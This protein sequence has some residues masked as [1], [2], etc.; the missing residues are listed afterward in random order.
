MN[1]TRQ[2]ISPFGPV[3]K[4]GINDDV[5]RAPY[6]IPVEGGN[7]FDESRARFDVR[8][9]RRGCL[10]LWWWRR[11]YYRLTPWWTS[12]L[13]LAVVPSAVAMILPSRAAADRASDYAY[14]STLDEFG[15]HYGSEPGIIELG[16]TVCAALD[17]GIET[18][19][20]ASVI[21]QAAHYSPGDANT[22]VGASIGSY[23]D[24]HIPA[25]A[26]KPASSGIG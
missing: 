2:G 13:L 10:H 22:I 9:P 3:R 21:A 14:L 23:C 26:T 11:L 25:A 8:Y 5:V 4:F 24:Q 20:I 15:V 16:H 18:G 19:R 7:S 6:A 12:V 17:R 1:D